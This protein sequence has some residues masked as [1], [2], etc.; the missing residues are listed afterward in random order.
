MSAG[1]LRFNFSSKLNSHKRRLVN[2]VGEKKLVHN[3]VGEVNEKHIMQEEKKNKALAAG[4][5]KV[6]AVWLYPVRT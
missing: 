4:Q 3:I 5:G 6:L 2:K 1:I